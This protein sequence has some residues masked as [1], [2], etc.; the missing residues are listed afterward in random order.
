[1]TTTTAT[2]QS[3]LDT[4]LAE[5]ASGCIPEE[6]R[7]PSI[8]PSL[9]FSDSTENEQELEDAA[10]PSE[11]PRRRRASTRL[12]AQSAADIQRITG[13]STAEVVKRCCGGGCC[14]KSAA[15]K[16]GVELEKPELPDNN[17]YQSLLLK[18]DAIPSTLTNV[19]DLPPQTAFL[20]SIRPAAAPS[21]PLPPPDS[22]I[23]FSPIDSSIPVPPTDS[24]PTV[25][26]AAEKLREL[27][28]NSDTDT[29]T[30]IQP[31]KFVQPH[32]PHNV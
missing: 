2:M 1:M 12:I 14:F 18:I 26:G 30:S 20:E 11:L 22:A 21:S 4:I 28:L 19:A 5:S 7:A 31:P 16:E 6:P 29:D 15:R 23:S 13:E 8:A 10:P 3:R 9:T 27:S 32:P 24:A 25:N 17:A